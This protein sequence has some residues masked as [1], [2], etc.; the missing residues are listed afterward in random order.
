[1]EP[2]YVPPSAFD[3][4]GVSRSDIPGLYQLNS[5][6]IGVEGKSGMRSAML[7]MLLAYCRCCG[8]NGYCCSTR[9]LSSE[10]GGMKEKPLRCVKSDEFER[11]VAMLVTLC[12][13]TNG[14]SCAVGFANRYCDAG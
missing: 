5:T 7:D 14:G 1:M 3:L 4:A 8:T 11:L 13:D 9:M 12:C 2:W 10:D 6:K